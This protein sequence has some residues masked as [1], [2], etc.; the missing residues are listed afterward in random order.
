MVFKSRE[1][2]IYF[3]LKYDGDYQK[4]LNAIKAREKINDLDYQTQ[5][6]ERNPIQAITIVDHDY[7]HAFKCIPNPPLVVFYKGDVSLLNNLDKAIAV[8]GAREYSDY[9]KEYTF[10]IVADLVKEGFLVVSGMARGIDGFAHEAALEGGGKTIAVLGSG[11]DY[12]YPLSNKDL[13]NEIS[14]NGLIISEYPGALKPEPEFFKFR[15][16]L[17]AALSRGLFIVEA[18]Y[19]S[20]TIIT[21][22]YALERGSDIFCLPERAGSESGTNKLIKDGAYLVESAADI[23]NLWSS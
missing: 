13:Y 16:R 10:K 11:I 15:N 22:S 19:R 1:I 14:Q 6:S 2:L 18:K 21:A 7:P 12:P 3:A 9:G 20:G 5:F 23:I 4:I 8:I 17:V